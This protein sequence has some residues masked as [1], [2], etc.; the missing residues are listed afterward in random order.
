MRIDLLK[1]RHPL[2]STHYNLLT[3][4]AQMTVASMIATAL[5]PLA[6]A[7]AKVE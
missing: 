6:T 3:L 1:A 7:A 4:N 2:S 5:A